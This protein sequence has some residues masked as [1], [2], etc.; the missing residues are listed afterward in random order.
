MKAAVNTGV[1]AGFRVTEVDIDAPR[2]RE[3]LVQVRASGLCHTDLSMVQAD[4]GIPFPAVLGHEIAGEV[5]AVGDAVEG[6]VPG[7]HVVGCLIRFCGRCTTCLAGRTHQCPNREATLRPP[8]APPRLHQGGRP[9]FQG[10]GLGGFAEQA[11]VH[12]NQLAVVNRQIPFSRAAV[13]GCATATGAGAVINSAQVRPHDQVAVFG[14]GGVGLNAVNAA[15][16]SGA[17]RIVAIDTVPAR[18]E[19]ARRFGATHVV[20]AAQEDPVAA[21]HRITGGGADHAFEVVG[22][23]EVQA[24][25]IASVRVGGTALLVGMA[26]PGTQLVLDSSL[27]MLSARKT[28]RAVGMGSTHLKRDLPY[29]ADLYMDGR[30]LLDELVTD[31]IALDDIGAAYERLTAGHGIRAVVT[32]F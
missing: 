27:Q 2:R 22:N 20:D 7:D 14:A 5:L 11:L 29:Y 10:F 26:R 19:R 4:Y 12:E 8:G 18:L 30:L 17:A 13:L 21:V 1:G 24:Q 25:A 3:V 32:S 16:L 6:I 15:R 31:E 9:V 28:I 23:A